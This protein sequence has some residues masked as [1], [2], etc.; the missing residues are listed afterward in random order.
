MMQLEAH[1]FRDLVVHMKM[2]LK[3]PLGF[4][5]HVHTITEYQ[6]MRCYIEGDRP[7]YQG[8]GFAIDQDGTL[9]NAF[10]LE[11]GRGD[12]LIEEAVRL[13]ANQLDCYDGYLSQLYARHGFVE[14]SREKWD[15]RYAD[16]QWIK[17]LWGEPDVVFMQRK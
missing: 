13:G 9:T 2:C 7:R 8:G 1:D 11:K 10:S 17:A 15:D 14:I 3:P 16:L 6:R 4:S 12:R 5:L